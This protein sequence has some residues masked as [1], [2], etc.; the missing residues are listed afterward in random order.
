MAK[1]GK[2]ALV[3]VAVLV[4]TRMWGN[5]TLPLAAEVKTYVN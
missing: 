3:V 1:Y 5:S 2:M 4:V